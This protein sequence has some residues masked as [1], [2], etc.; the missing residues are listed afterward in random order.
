[1]TKAYMDTL[2]NKIRRNIFRIRCESIIQKHLVSIN[3]L[4]FGVDIFG[5][6]RQNTA[7]LIQRLVRE[8]EDFLMELEDFASHLIHL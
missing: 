1:M 7:Y 3:N 2:P 8:E 4:V 6:P 5:R